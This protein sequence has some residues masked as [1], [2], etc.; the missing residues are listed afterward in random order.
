MFTPKSMGFHTE[1]YH[2]IPIYASI[3]YFEAA[4]FEEQTI[5]ADFIVIL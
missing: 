1:L 3:F 5:C 4:L 2:I